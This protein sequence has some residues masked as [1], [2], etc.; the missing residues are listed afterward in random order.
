MK[1]A[2]MRDW[3]KSLREQAE[4]TQ[5]QI[6]DKLGITKQYYQMIEAGNRQQNMDLTLCSKLSELFGISLE[7]IA[8]KET[9]LKAQEVT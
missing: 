2:K 5:Q 9:E 3:L 7:E 1:L 4:L 6:A 8:I